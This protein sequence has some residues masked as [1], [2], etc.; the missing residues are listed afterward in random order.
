MGQQLLERQ[1]SLRGMPAFF[2]LGDVGVGWRPVHVTQCNLERRQVERI[3]HAGWH[4]ILDRA[5]RQHRQRHVGQ[6]A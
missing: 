6:H 3:E 4:V 1:P 5:L 2:E